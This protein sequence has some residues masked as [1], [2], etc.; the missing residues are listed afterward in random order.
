MQAILANRK[1]FVRKFEHRELKL[2]L[3][4]ELSIS[5]IWPEA[6]KLPRFA[7]YMPDEWSLQNVKKIEREFMFGQLI[8]LAPEYVEMLVLDIRKQRLEQNATR[9]I[10]PRVIAVSNDWVGQLLS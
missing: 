3:W 8:T 2:P 9:V 5:R 1:R 7:E 4:P 10:K 6:M